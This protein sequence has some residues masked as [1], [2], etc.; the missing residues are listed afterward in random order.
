MP[1][2]CILCG[3][4]CEMRCGR[5]KSVWYCSSAHQET[6]W[7]KHKRECKA[8]ATAAEKKAEEAKG[9]L[10]EIRKQMPPSYYGGASAALQLAESLN[11]DH[12]AASN[13]LRP[14][15][16]AIRFDEIA[17]QVEQEQL[18]VQ[19]CFLVRKEQQEKLFIK[20]LR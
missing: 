13:D 9:D 15:F 8:L 5:C 1:A 4:V 6:D 2:N 19:D 7:P 16:H 12:N 20:L 10:Y 17:K 11:Y 18:L 3:A 14:I